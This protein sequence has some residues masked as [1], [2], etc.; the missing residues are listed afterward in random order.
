MKLPF[1][2]VPVSY[3]HLPYAVRLFLA[4]NLF[5]GF[6]VALQQQAHLF[7][8]PFVSHNV[9]RYHESHEPYV[10]LPAVVDD[11]DVVNEPM[12]ADDDELKTDTLNALYAC[13]AT[14]AATMLKDNQAVIK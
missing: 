11:V 6:V 10:W 13:Y 1:G 12:F 5:H 9:G 3:T 2:L 4:V 14:L 7:R 8:F